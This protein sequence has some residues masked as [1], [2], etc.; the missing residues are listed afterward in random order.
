[1]SARWRARAAGAIGPAVL[2]AVAATLTLL[3]VSMSLYP[4]GTWTD[5]GTVGHDFLGNFLCDLIAA[6]AVGGAPNPGAAFGRWALVACAVGLAGAWWI[7]PVVPRPGGRAVPLLRALGLAS[8][9]GAVA[10]AFLPSDRH[11]EWHRLAV[12]TA[13][14]P[15]FV[16]AAWIVVRSLA[17]TGRARG[18]A[19]LLGAALAVAVADFALY[20]A[21]ARGAPTPALLP[22]LQK[23]AFGLVLAW[24]V[25]LGAG[26]APRA[27]G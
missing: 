19:A 21:A 10:V 2:G 11:P 15:A 7:A 9:A 5:P 18:Q 20:V 25:W 17:S 22:A 26:G 3:G 4:G 6:R 12:L 1:M 24:M 13:G 8:S 27:R 14:P 23:L 16:A